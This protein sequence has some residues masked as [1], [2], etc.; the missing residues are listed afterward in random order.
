MRESSNSLK[1]KAKSMA[2][3]H[4][5][6][7]QEIMQNYMFER[8]LSRIAKSRY[9]NNFILKGGLLLSSISGIQSRTTMDMDTMIKGLKFEKENLEVILNEILKMD[10]DDGVRFEITGI[11]EIREDDYY[12]GFRF[13]INAYLDNIRNYLS[14]DIST[15]DI[16]T[17]REEDHQYKMTFENEYIQIKSC[18]IET[19]LAEKI[20][21]VLENNGARGRMKDYYDIWYFVN[22]HWENIDFDL[23]NIALKCT[24]T[25]RSSIDDLRRTAEILFIIQNS[26]ILRKRWNEFAPKHKYSKEI[27]FECVMDAMFDFV[28]KIRISETME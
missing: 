15:G 9:H 13:K 16:I 25:Q 6:T 3:L 8:I 19:F 10:M 5:V 24:C 11:E 7:V 23:F 18:N 28:N 20:Q 17:P 27:S 12:G 22:F 21:T 1:L 14:I 2:I 4:N 26:L